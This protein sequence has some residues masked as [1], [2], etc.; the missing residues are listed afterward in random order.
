MSAWP[1]RAH[2]DQFVG[3]ALFAAPLLP[4]CLPSAYTQCRPR[5]RPD[6]RSLSVIDLPFSRQSSRARSTVYLSPCT[7]VDADPTS[8]RVHHPAR[9]SL[10][11]PPARN[12]RALPA[13]SVE[14]APNQSRSAVPREA[15]LVTF[16]HNNNNTVQQQEMCLPVPLIK[17]DIGHPTHGASRTRACSCMHACT[18]GLQLALQPAPPPHCQ[19]HLSCVR[20]RSFGAA[21]MKDSR[22]LSLVRRDIV[23]SPGANLGVRLVDLLLSWRPIP[24]EDV[25]ILT[26]GTT[27]QMVTER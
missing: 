16:A 11:S 27:L 12:T 20:P 19:L 15:C 5:P 2:T 4:S 26:S 13:R 8:S 22:R 1:V 14:P 25:C 23:Q 10:P 17:T 21:C 18:R 24:R 3:S 6:D 9:S 7:S